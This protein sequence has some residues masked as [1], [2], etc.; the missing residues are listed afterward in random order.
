MSHPG[1]IRRL[2]RALS[3]KMLPV[4]IKYG[5]NEARTDDVLTRAVNSNLFAVGDDD[6][7]T[8]SS[9]SLEDYVERLR[10]DKSARHLFPDPEPDTKSTAMICGLPREQFNALP[11][12]RRL[13]L[14]NRENAEN[15]RRRK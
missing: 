7:L 8:P 6:E 14:A 9:W 13:E 2:R 12:Q 3:E 4:A 10:E 11:A 15:A 5:L 1:Q